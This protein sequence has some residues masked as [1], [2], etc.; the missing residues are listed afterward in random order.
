M[1][2]TELLAQAANDKLAEITI[3]RKTRRFPSIIQM[4]RTKYHTVNG[5]N[6]PKSYNRSATI[7]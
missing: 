5:R 1:R 7:G 6:V 4:M 2:S 3:P